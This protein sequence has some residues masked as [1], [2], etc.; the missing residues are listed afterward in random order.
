MG[1]MV[2]LKVDHN[3]FLPGNI[4][5]QKRKQAATWRAERKLTK[6]EH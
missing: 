3:P 1:K 6:H 2:I 5:N 4:S